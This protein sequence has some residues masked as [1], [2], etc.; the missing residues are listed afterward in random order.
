MTGVTGAAAIPGAVRAAQLSRAAASLDPE[1]AASI[2]RVASGLASRVQAGKGN[3]STSD[4]ASAMNDQLQGE[5][6]A[7]VGR[8]GQSGALPDGADKAV[9]QPLMAAA[10]SGTLAPSDAAIPSSALAQL[11]A[12]PMQDGDKAA[13]RSGLLDLSTLNRDG[14]PGGALQ[15]LAEK[16]LNTGTAHAIETLGGAGLGLL[17]G[18][19]AGA[20]LGGIAGA[21]VPKMVSGLAG[22]IDQLTGANLPPVLKQ[23]AAARLA[24]QRAGAAMPGDALASLQAARQAYAPP[25]GPTPEQQGQQAAAARQAAMVAKY[26]PSHPVGQAAANALNDSGNG[27]VAVKALAQYAAQAPLRDAAPAGKAWDAAARHQGNIDAAQ[28]TPGGNVGM[29]A[30]NAAANELGNKAQATMRLAGAAQGDSAPPA[31][32]PQ[33]PASTP[34]A[35]SPAPTPSGASESGNG[36]SPPASGLMGLADYLASE[37]LWRGGV[38]LSPADISVGLDR[39]AAG[40]HLTP[41]QYTT[42]SQRI[43]ANVPLHHAAGAATPALEAVLAHAVAAKAGADAAMSPG[44]VGA[45]AQA[46]P[47]STAVRDTVKY[48]TAA[49][50]NQAT[51]GAAIS[52]LR[53]EGMPEAAQAVADIRHESDSD[54]RAAVLDGLG[55]VAS[56][57]AKALLG[58]KLYGK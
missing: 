41:D 13:L 53:A 46:Q 56:A 36:I 33:P 12:M 43:T 48:D 30:I 31:G 34:A 10:K 47:A 35:Q 4:A 45:P 52:T 14:K 40:G 6:N 51:Y 42:L 20:I 5:L 26:G 22:G 25:S 28:E 37:G 21:T 3:V 38:A 57:R 15:P 23:Q 11:D 9:I 49:R 8:L 50:A 54:T 32:G 24:L 39:A 44:L 17:H 19:D 16:L 55:P 7:H 2:V 27:D 29:D 18:G 1:Q 58:K